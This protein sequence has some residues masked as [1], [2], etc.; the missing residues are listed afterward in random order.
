MI[1]EVKNVS[2]DFI[3]ENIKKECPAKD[4]CLERYEYKINLIAENTYK[5]E[6]DEALNLINSIKRINKKSL[7]RIPLN[8]DCRECINIF[9]SL[10]GWQ[11]RTIYLI[12]ESNKEEN[13]LDMNENFI[14]YEL[15]NF[16]H[17]KRL[18]LLKL[19]L[20][21]SLNYI[22]IS[23]NL[24]LKGGHLTYHLKKLTEGGY[25]SK[26]D[27]RYIITSKGINILKILQQIINNR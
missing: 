2:L 22:E 23:K 26:S 9:E 18:Q 12:S 25:I 1:D 16:S 11:K 7:E 15:N 3:R 24:K 19:L 20:K 13:L 6:I 4:E 17:P 8:V 27:N 5:G 14:C 21:G 10:L